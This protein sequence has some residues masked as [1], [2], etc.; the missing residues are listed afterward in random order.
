[1]TKTRQQFWDMQRSELRNELRINLPGPQTFMKVTMA[2]NLI[3]TLQAPNAEAS[4]TEMQANVT[5]GVQEV[6]ETK[7]KAHPGDIRRVL[8]GNKKG[9]KKTRSANNIMWNLHPMHMESQD[10]EDSDDKNLLPPPLDNGQASSSDDDGSVF[11]PQK[12]VD[13]YWG[14]QDDQFFP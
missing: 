2:K 3:R 8:G 13:D 9:D 4:G 7:G 10:S 11:N 5:K 6:N 12:L 1:M 14:E